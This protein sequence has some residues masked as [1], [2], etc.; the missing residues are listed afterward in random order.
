MK[1]RWA[2]FKEADRSFGLFYPRHYVVAGFDTYE[3][4][5]TVARQFI[6]AGFAH[7]DVAAAT[8]PFVAQRLE[9]RRS[10]NWLQRI[11]ASIAEAVGTEA[12]YIEDDL[13]L[14]RRGGA[15]LFVYVPDAA[16]GKRARLLLRRSHPVYA[17]RYHPLGIERLIYPPQSTL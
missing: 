5:Q 13:K 8:G 12:G 7:D 2:F 9:S 4:A 1:Q 16:A 14:A 11:E 10:A 15:F 3:R 6:E 17:R